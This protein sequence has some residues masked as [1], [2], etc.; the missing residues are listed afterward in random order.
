M[1]HAAIFDV[2]LETWILLAL[3]SSSPSVAVIREAGRHAIA[4]L[5]GIPHV[6]EIL[7]SY[8]TNIL[9]SLDLPSFKQ[10]PPFV[11]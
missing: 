1:L 11:C 10:D 4:T 7:S 2:V 8:I 3:Y 5:L 9:L 6:L